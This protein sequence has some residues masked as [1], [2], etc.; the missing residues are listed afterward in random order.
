MTTV[1]QICARCSAAIVAGARFCMHCG[2]DA[3]TAPGGG[4]AFGHRRTGEAIFDIQ[5]ELRERLTRATLG[6][7]EIRRQLGQGGMATVYLAHDLALDRKV[8][9]KVMA[10]GLHLS[11]GMAERFKLEARTAASL[12]HRHIIPIYSV[13][14]AEG[15]LFFVMK[16]VEGRSLDDL[17][18]R[19]GAL[20]P[21]QVCRILAQVGDALAYAHRKGVIHR[22][23]KP[24]NII[25]DEEDCAIVTDFG[26]AK[27]AEARGLT[28]TGATVGTPTYMSPEQCTGKP[29]S[30]ASDQYSLGIVAYELL[31]GSVPFVADTVMPIMFAHVSTPPRPLVEVRPALPEGLSAAVMRMLEKPPEAR[32]PGMP[33]VA[34]VFEA[35]ARGRPPVGSDP[36]IPRLPLPGLPNQAAASVTPRSPIPAT[37]SLGGELPPAPS[38]APEPEARARGP[39]V[40]P[41]SGTLAVG[42]AVPMALTIPGAGGKDEVCP[43]VSWQSTDPAVARVSSEGVVTAIGAGTVTIRATGQVGEG[44]AVLTVTRVGVARLAIFAP[45]RSIPVSDEVQLQ[46]TMHDRFGGKLGGRLATWSSADP[47]VATVSPAGVVTAMSEGLT[48]ISVASGGRTAVIGIKVTAPAVTAIR[49]SPAESAMAIGEQRRLVASAVNPRGRVLFSLPVTWASSD[50]TIAT[51][52]ADGTVSGHRMGSVKIAAT[53]AGRRSVATVTVNPAVR[54]R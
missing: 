2:H 24:A 22:D 29:I 42:D 34:A 1:T 18:R 35:L 52:S 49:L 25:L 9:I 8:A 23:I 27:V 44:S 15:L 3:T 46:V 14:Q 41:A 30:G 40:F 12:S 17:V 6:D 33:E 50:P 31:T 47:G 7:Y 21:T 11:E 39:V 28:M 38:V 10:P 53:V 37:R 19:G 5:D 16:Y 26:I 13:K 36:L 20:E 43:D 4:G 32:W 51:V 45:N 54:P 48:E